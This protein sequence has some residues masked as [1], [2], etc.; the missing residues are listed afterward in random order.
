MDDRLLFKTQQI[1]ISM[2][3]FIAVMCCYTCQKHIQ[4]LQITH[5]QT[6][7]ECGDNEQI[8]MRL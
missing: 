6:V 4:I 1:W 2:Y 3:I 7:P 5:L 8:S